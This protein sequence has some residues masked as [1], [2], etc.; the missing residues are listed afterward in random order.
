[1][2]DV[3]GVKTFDLTT[4]PS[5]DWNLHIFYYPVAGASSEERQ[6]LHLSDKTMY[7]YVGPHGTTSTY[8]RGT[9]NI[10]TVIQRAVQENWPVGQDRNL[11]FLLLST[12]SDPR[13]L[14][15]NNIAVNRKQILKT[16]K[17]L[18][19]TKDFTNAQ[20]LYD[21]IPSS[22]DYQYIHTFIGTTDS[23]LVSRSR[24]PSIFHQN[25]SSS[26]HSWVTFK[27]NP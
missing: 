22:D 6:R 2:E 10:L 14:Q 9:L 27:N 20:K 15:A 17:S 5:G 8:Y 11:W 3:T 18:A 19:V 16:F 25:L 12:N 24:V 23:S 26:K 7:R 21:T 4:I 13:G 1:V